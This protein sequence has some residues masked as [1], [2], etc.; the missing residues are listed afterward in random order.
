MEKNTIDFTIFLKPTV[1]ISHL[2]LFLSSEKRN[3]ASNT[4]T[5]KIGTK[6]DTVV[7]YKS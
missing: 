4:H 2:L 5:D 7:T 1:N 6:R 3:T